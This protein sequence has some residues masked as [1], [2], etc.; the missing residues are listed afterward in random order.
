MSNSKYRYGHWESHENGGSSIFTRV[1]REI[2]EEDAY[3]KSM[4]Q[5]AGAISINFIAITNPGVYLGH[6]CIC[7]QNGLMRVTSCFLEDVFCNLMSIM[8]INIH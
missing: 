5:P 3:S 7:A 8:R 1:I 6:P 4:I 2:M